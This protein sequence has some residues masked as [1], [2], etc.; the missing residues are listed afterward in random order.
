MSLDDGLGEVDAHLFGHRR[1]QRAQQ[2][3]DHRRPLL[4]QHLGH[5]LRVGEEQQ[6]AGL[7]GDEPLDLLGQERDPLV[8]RDGQDLRGPVP[9][10]LG[11]LGREVFERVDA[12]LAAEGDRGEQQHGL[13][14]GQAGEEGVHACSGL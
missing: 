11:F 1:G 13:A 5:H 3:L 7:G 12:F 14:L 2:H 4:G 9:E 6:V 8:A 10:Q